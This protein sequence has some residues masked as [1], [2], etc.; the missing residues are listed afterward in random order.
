MRVSVIVPTY[1]ASDFLALCLDALVTQDYH[2][3]EVIVVDNGSQDTTCKIVQRYG[4][5]KLLFQNEIQ[6]SYAARNVGITHASGDLIAFTDADCIPDHDWI[7]Q[8]VISFD[9]HGCDMIGGRVEFFYSPQRTGAEI[10]D[11]LVNM[12]NHVCIPERG[13]AKTANFFAKKS[14]FDELGL[15]PEVQSGGD[16][17]YSGKATKSG[18][19]LL[20]GEN[21]R[22]KHPAR[23]LKELLGKSLRTGAGNLSVRREANDL[24]WWKLTKSFAWALL[25]PPHPGQLRNKLQRANVASGWKTVT[26]V[27]VAAY[28]SSLA[29]RFAAIWAFM[30]EDSS[31]AV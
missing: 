25:V 23:K 4:S 18:Y 2:D 10:Y 19:R 22:V 15:F 13:V 27:L 1:N 30:Q 14:I 29:F 7:S 9:R 5:V 3:F 28:L 21:V 20:Y 17:L 16:V 26:S 24:S 12:Q 8:A 6:S 11:S 31:D